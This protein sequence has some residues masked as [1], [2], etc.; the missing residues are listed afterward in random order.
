MLLLRNLI[1]LM[2]LSTPRLLFAQAPNTLPLMLKGDTLAYT[3]A[4]FEKQFLDS[5]LQLLAQKY[6]ITENEAYIKQAKIW[7]QPNMN[8]EHVLYN[9]DKKTFFGTG[10][11]SEASAQVKGDCW[12]I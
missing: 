9:P 1:I 10:D 8:F 4:Q 3:I 7:D 6:N 12:R 2:I 5:N 11:S